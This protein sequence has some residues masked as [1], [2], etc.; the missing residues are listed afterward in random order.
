MIKKCSLNKAVFSSLLFLTILVTGVSCNASSVDDA[1]VPDATV[2]PT[3]IPTQAPNR[4]I[5]V[6][7]GDITPEELAEAQSFISQLAAGSN[8]VFETRETISS[9]EITPDVK[10]AIFLE[11]P[12]NLGSLAASAPGTQFVAISDQDW[13]PPANGSIIRLKNDYVA[14]LSG[15]LSA[16]IAP[17]FR[18]GALLVSEQTSFNQ[19]YTNGVSYYCGI[20]AALVFPLNTYPVVTLQPAASPPANWQ[21]AFNEIN[22]NKVNVLFLPREIVSAELGA[23]LATQD[24]AIIGNGPPPVELSEKWVATVKSDGMGALQEI[25]TDLVGGIGG[26]TI[27]ANI[28]FSDI[29]YVSVTDGL[30]WLSQGK[31]QQLDE[32][33]QLIR[34][35][36]IYPYD[37]IQ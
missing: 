20:C 2:Q 27:N 34:D 18:A 17:N 8:L 15:Y 29:N 22:Q 24:V 7:P 5:L 9:N 30:V 1:P 6:S 11:Q 37:V 32:L 3:N 26:K 36:Q 25:W 14:F 16:M 33:V 23:F 19:A 31:L 28:T 12:D 13:N 21:A 10:I 4:V 35:D